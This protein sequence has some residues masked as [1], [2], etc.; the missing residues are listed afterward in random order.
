MKLNEIK[1]YN[2]KYYKI[3]EID[4]IFITMINIDTNK[5]SIFLISN[6]IQNFDTLTLQEY[7]KYRIKLLLDNSLKNKEF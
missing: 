3:V 4:K 2:N 1:K 7:R 6:V 5:K